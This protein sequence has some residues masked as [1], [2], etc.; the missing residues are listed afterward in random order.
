MVATLKATQIVLIAPALL[1]VV[2]GVAGSS[3]QSR[4]S[5]YTSVCQEIANTISDASEVYYPCMSCLD[6]IVHFTR[7]FNNYE[8]WKSRIIRALSTGHHQ[9]LK[10]QHAQLS[11]VPHKTLG[12]SYVAQNYS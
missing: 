11:L 9:A 3:I 2:A 6:F 4:V 1:G 5:S 12:S 7:E 8:Q 10:T